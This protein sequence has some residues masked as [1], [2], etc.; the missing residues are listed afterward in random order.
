MNRK[1]LW[2]R[3]TRKHCFLMLLPFVGYISCNTNLC[4]E[5][6]TISCPKP[7]DFSKAMAF[8]GW[9]N[10]PFSI[11]V[12]Q[13]GKTTISMNTFGPPKKGNHIVICEYYGRLN[14]HSITGP[15]TIPESAWDCQISQPTNS[16]TC[17]SK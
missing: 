3:K 16:V 8:S 4:A 14:T 11:G 5:I 9:K 7:E 13:D 15:I 6:I 12:P 10:N 2:L 1:L 17:N